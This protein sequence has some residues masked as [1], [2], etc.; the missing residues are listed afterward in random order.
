MAERR[1]RDTGTVGL[2]LGKFA[3]FHKGHQLLVETALAET[4]RVIVIIYD[5]PETISIPLPVRAGWI[6]RLYPDV[7]VLEAWDGPT[8]TGYTPEI[9]R[10]QEQ[11]VLKLLDGRKV[12]HFYSSERYGE[13][14]SEALGAVD[15]RVDPARIAVP[16]SG[17]AVRRAPYEHRSFLDPIVYRDL[18]VKAVFLGA[19]ST[20]KTTVAQAMAERLGTVWMPEYGREY[21]ERHHVDRRLAPEQMVEIAEGHLEREEALTAEA[22]DVLFVDTNAITTYMFALDYHGFAL[23]RLR[24]LAERAASR[25]DL[26]FLCADDIPYDDTPDRSGDVHRRKFQKQIRADLLIRHIPFVTLE[27]SLEKRME[28]VEAAVRQYAKY[29]GL[30]DLAVP[31]RD[32]S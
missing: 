8:E 28:R 4:D 25:Y 1:E 7:E 24:E 31:N 29:G 20:G 13:H 18:V 10:M 9:M 21:W 27:G 19:P 14:M 12:T 30:G 2:T 23:P 3:P 32:H 17:T 15:R 6:R 16:V 22:R 11:Y 5:C 26:V